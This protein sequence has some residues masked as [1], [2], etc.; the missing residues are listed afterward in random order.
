MWRKLVLATCCVAS[1]ALLACATPLSMSETRAS[2][3]RL[4]HKQG[5][6]DVEWD[7]TEVESPA[8]AQDPCKWPW[9]SPADPAVFPW[10]DVVHVVSMVRRVMSGMRLSRSTRRHLPHL[11][12]NKHP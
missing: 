8:Q 12:R 6:A 7:G 5:H 1:A 9:G 10:V 4:S 11:R 2:E 3:A